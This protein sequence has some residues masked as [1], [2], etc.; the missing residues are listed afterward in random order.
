MEKGARVKSQL[1]KISMSKS[2]QWPNKGCYKDNLSSK[3]N[4]RLLRPVKSGDAAAMLRSLEDAEQKLADV[5]INLAADE[6]RSRS[7]L[8]QGCRHVTIDKRC[9]KLQKRMKISGQEIE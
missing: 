9:R 8:P 6:T 5:R 4:L 7:T 3:E 2:T 1:E